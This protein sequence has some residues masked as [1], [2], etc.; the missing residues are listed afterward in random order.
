MREQTGTRTISLLA[1]I[2]LPHIGE[3]RALETELQSLSVPNRGQAER[4]HSRARVAPNLVVITS[5]IVKDTTLRKDALYLVSG[6]V[7]VRAGVTVTIEDG[8]TVLIKNGRKV[9]GKI[10]TSALIFD[11]GSALRAAVVT[12][13]SADEK[14]ERVRDPNNGGVFFCGST[15]SGTKDGISSVRQLKSSD[16][17]AERIVLDHV[18]RPDPREGDGDNNDRDDIDSVSVIGVGK[19]EWSITAIESRGSGDDGIDLYNSSIA[20]DTL[21][22][23]DPT[24]DGVNL[25]S[26]RLS[27]RSYSVI[28]TAAREGEDRELFDFEND[29]GPS[30]ISVEKGALV[31]LSGRWGSDADDALLK[32]DDMPRPPPR[33]ASYTHYRFEGTLAKPATIRSSK[34]D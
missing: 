14:G 22:V 13:A 4:S 15:R 31:K 28:D 30:K 34:D 5:D 7:H 24:E 23:T 12:F 9:G 27:V 10:D 25:T 16:F 3:S 2:T 21:I 33:G 29:H 20:L 19:R 1:A 17:R 18:G 26:S 32:S 11:S 8:V 6:E